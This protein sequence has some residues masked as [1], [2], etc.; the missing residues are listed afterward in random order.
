MGIRPGVEAAVT[1]AE[2]V[3]GIFAGAVVVQSRFRCGVVTAVDSTFLLTL[4]C[5][6]L[7]VEMVELLTCL[8]GL[9]ML[10]SPLKP[11]DSSDTGGKGALIQQ[12]HG[13]FIVSSETIHLPNTQRVHDEY[14]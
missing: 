13:E 10:N 8:K 2:E 14:F 4:L 11:I 1:C 9:I 7:A 12:A 5:S 6:K 3:E